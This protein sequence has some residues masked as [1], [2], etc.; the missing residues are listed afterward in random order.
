MTV[1]ILIIIL[2]FSSPSQLHFYICVP[3][4]LGTYSLSAHD[5]FLLTCLIQTCMSSSQF[6]QICAVSSSFFAK[7]IR[8]LIFHPPENQ[9]VPYSLDASLSPSVPLMNSSSFN[10]RLAADLPTKLGPWHPILDCEEWNR[11]YFK[12][13]SIDALKKKDYGYQR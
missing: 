4:I 11:S 7:L 13:E 12:Y 6:K 9:P 3:Q 2:F 8:L 1:T 10:C 5:S